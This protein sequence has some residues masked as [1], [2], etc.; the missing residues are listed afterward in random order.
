MNRSHYDLLHSTLVDVIKTDPGEIDPELN[1]LESGILDSLD[2]M[3]YIF[4]L[5]K[6]SEAAF[7]D[8]ED[9]DFDMLTF[10]KL[11]EFFE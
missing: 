11:S 1:L 4:N 8:V 7:G 10:Q 5:Q 2:A 9:F 3:N 6:K